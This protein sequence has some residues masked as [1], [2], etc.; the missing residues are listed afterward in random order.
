[1]Q[2]A[3]TELAMWLTVQRW[4]T[5]TVPVLRS[6]V[7]PLSRTTRCRCCRRS[8]IVSGRPRWCSGWSGW[9]AAII[10]SGCSGSPRKPGGCCLECGWNCRDGCLRRL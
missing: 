9:A 2:A 7:A 1:M 8:C 3:S 6:R 5:S 10:R 4:S